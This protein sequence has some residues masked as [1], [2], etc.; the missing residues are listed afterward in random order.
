MMLSKK[1][2]GR[3]ADDAPV[4]MSYSRQNKGQALSAKTLSNICM[5]YLGTSKV[6]ALRHT[7][8]VESEK[9][10]I[11]ISEISFRLG[12]SNEAITSRYLKQ[13]RSAENPHGKMLAARFG[14]RRRDK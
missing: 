4:W 8:A 14:I 7:N 6:H 3:L 12:H 2:G 11:P 1:P 9:A 13:K 5:R 10:G